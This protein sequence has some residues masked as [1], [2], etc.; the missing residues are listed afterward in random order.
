MSFVKLPRP[1]ES[2]SLS[3]R[4][5]APKYNTLNYAVK[6]NEVIIR[7]EKRKGDKP[8]LKMLCPAHDRHSGRAGDGF[9]NLR[10]PPKTTSGNLIGRVDRAFV[11][12]GQRPDGT[13]K[14]GMSSIPYKRCAKQLKID[15]MF[16]IPVTVEQAKRVETFALQNIGA[17]VHD[18]EWV[19]C[20]LE[21]AV[22]AV[23]VAWRDVEKMFHV[24]PL[25]THE[26]SRLERISACS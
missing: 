7:T 3:K 9:L 20:S 8:G 17:T 24:N 2:S 18:S 4:T 15:L 16:S 5:P 6:G 22:D 10:P 19:K 12:V 26:E 23:C 25:I 14:I 11:Y 13:V 21:Q 1:E